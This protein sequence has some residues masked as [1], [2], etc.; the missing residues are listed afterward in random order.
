MEDPRMII[1]WREKRPCL[2][3]WESSRSSNRSASMGRVALSSPCWK[4]SVS[5]VSECM[6]SFI[7]FVIKTPPQ[8][9]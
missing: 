3:F 5:N 7:G 2:L 8:A 4:K 6:S 9:A 1:D